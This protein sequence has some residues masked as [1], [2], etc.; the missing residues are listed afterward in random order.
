MRHSIRIWNG[1][2][3]IEGLKHNSSLGG[4]GREEWLLNTHCSYMNL[5]IH[6]SKQSSLLAQRLNGETFKQVKCQSKQGISFLK[7]VIQYFRIK[8]IGNLTTDYNNHFIISLSNYIAAFNLFVSCLFV[9]EVHNVHNDLLIL[10]LW[11][12]FSQ[13]YLASIAN[14]INYYVCC[15]EICSFLKCVYTFY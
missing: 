15:P 10:C 12:I 11:F 2:N 5:S 13:L 1:Q 8:C 7:M 14:S 6:H 4:C 3:A 9:Y